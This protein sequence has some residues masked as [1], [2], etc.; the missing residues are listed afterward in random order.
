MTPRQKQVI[1]VIGGG[2]AGSEGVGG[3]EFVP[4]RAPARRVST[5]AASGGGF[6]ADVFTAIARE[7][8]DGRNAHTTDG[9]MRTLRR[10]PRDFADF[11]QW[12]RPAQLSP[13]TLTDEAIDYATWLLLGG[14]GGHSPIPRAAVRR[15]DGE[16]PAASGARRPW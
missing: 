10:P 1:H 12:G 9:V 7:T 2:L 8:L 13:G 6:V 16:R 3:A 5:I 4:E 14:R 15:R 11:A